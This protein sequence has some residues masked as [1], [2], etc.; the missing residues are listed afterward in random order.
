MPFTSNLL[1]VDPPVAGPSLFLRL[2]REVPAL[3]EA[4]ELLDPPAV[5]TW[6]DAGPAEPEVPL[7]EPV[8]L[9]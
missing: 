2:R 8:T 1:Q 6:Q 4:S 5:D 9:P 7:G 3:A